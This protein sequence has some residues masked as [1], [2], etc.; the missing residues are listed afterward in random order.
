[1]YEQKHRLGASRT[2]AQGYLKPGGIIDFMQDCSCFQLDADPT[3]SAY[4]RQ[5]G[6]GMYL[7]SRQIDILRLPRYG[8]ELTVRTFV[9]ACNR[10]YGHRNTFIYTDGEPC[11]KSDCTGV[12]VDL[13]SGRPYKMPQEILD[14]VPMDPQQDMQVLPH[15]FELPADGWQPYPPTPVLRCQIDQNRHVNNARYLDVAAEYLPE[16]FRYNRIRISYKTPARYGDVFYPAT[17]QKDDV[18]YVSLADQSDRLYCVTAFT[19]L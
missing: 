5:H 10:L 12:F 3:L 6:V 9:Y 2:D 15:K 14:A 11:I 4:F 18:C 19:I 17:C 1:M 8:E 7:A 13:S 16:D